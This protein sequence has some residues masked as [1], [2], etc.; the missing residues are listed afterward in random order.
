[1]PPEGS[2]REDTGTTQQARHRSCPACG[3]PFA[4]VGRQAYCST[5]C[6]KRA[7]RIRNAAPR[8]GLPT[9]VHR[10]EHTVYE[11]P[12][13]GQRQ[14]GVQRCSDCGVFGRAAGLG[15][16]CPHCDEPVTLTDLALTEVGR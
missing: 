12:D 9:G 15:G 14:L 16:A 11:C 2:Y 8:P 3:Q 10:R 1:M 7:F 13:C 4:S 5:R 6:R